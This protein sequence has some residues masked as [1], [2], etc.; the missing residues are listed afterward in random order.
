MGT[1]FTG[2]RSAAGS[3]FTGGCSATDP[4]SMENAVRQGLASL[5][6]AEPW[7]LGS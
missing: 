3:G 7:A 4:V 6:A 5:E 2:G 1:G